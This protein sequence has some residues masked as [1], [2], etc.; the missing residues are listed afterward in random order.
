MTAGDSASA[1]LLL[2][3]PALAMLFDGAASALM[4]AAVLLGLA[5]LPTGR[6][7]HP[8]RLDGLGRAFCIALAAPLAAVALSTL[9]HGHPVFPVWDS[10]SRFLLVIPVFLAL[11]R[12]PERNL[13][14]A[15][16]AFPA[17]ALATLFIAIFLSHDWSAGDHR[18]G[19]KFLNPI[20]FG[21]LALA[22]GVLS[23]AALNWWRKDKPWV[24]ALKIAG[25]FAGLATSL[26]SGSRGGWLALPCVLAVILWERG[27]G[28]SLRWKVL[29]PLAIVALF[30]IVY[31]A[32]ST[33]RERIDVVASNLTQYEHG[34]EDTSVGVRLQ[35]YKVAVEL[36]AQHPVLGLG[37]HGFRDAMNSMAQQ[38]RLTPA[39]AQLG[40]GEVHNQLLAYAA[41]YGIVGG[42]A[43]LAIYAVPA[44]FFARR[45][46]SASAVAH[47]T[48]MLGLLFIVM[49]FVFGL[50][51]E[52]FDLKGT[53]SIYVLI[54]AALAAIA[55][56]TD[57]GASNASPV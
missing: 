30:G 41:D 2:T 3:Y 11:R 50:T 31:G 32:S 55:D 33:V 54:V 7:G 26:L 37:G 23:A 16:L 8:V 51:V 56:R 9:A 1:F 36:I 52:T 46:R 19:S 20:H 28:K 25:L 18:L 10:P 45:L 48:A 15:D 27:R 34:H 40:K 35:L 6:A 38:G 44:L 47:N 57:N 29:M 21:D 14:W 43:L 17:G 42:L 39:A 49:F 13:A 24:V 22:F 5:A 4:I 53:V 12:R